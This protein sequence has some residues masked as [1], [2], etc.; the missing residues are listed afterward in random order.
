M[1]FRPL[2]ASDVQCRA[3]EKLACESGVAHASA[4]ITAIFQERCQM[5]IS[6]FVV[7]NMGR[8]VALGSL[9]AE[10][11]FFRGGSKAA[12]ILDLIVQPGAHSMDYAQLLLDGLKQ[13]AHL[14]GCYKMILNCG[15][16]AQELYA[17][18]GYEQKEYQMQLPLAP[19]I[20]LLVN[21]RVRKL[22][23]EDLDRGFRESLSA[24]RTMDVP[25]DKIDQVFQERAAQGVHTYVL[26]T[27][28]L[29]DGGVV[30]T[31]SMILLTALDGGKMA[32]IE[33]VA[34]DAALQGQGLGRM[35]MTAMKI[36]AYA[37]GCTCIKL[38]CSDQNVTFYEKN[39]YRKVAVQMRQ[40]L[41]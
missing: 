8:I 26:A 37:K 29:G 20:E 10:T 19:S 35:M 11:K 4:K 7:E 34:V 21:Y 39:N 24:L 13:Q 3:I 28:A 14:A 41:G 31:A 30:A 5:R 22:R 33:D 17:E 1:I 15:S 36:K 40:D 25:A 32:L 2:T 12:H 16:D 9:L 6:S 23:V 27:G 18:N 38:D